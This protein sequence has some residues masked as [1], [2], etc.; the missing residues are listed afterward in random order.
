MDEKALVQT[1]FN[2]KKQKEDLESKQTD[3]KNQ[4]ATLDNEIETKEKDLLVFMKESD[5]KEIDLTDIVATYF[6]KENVS[7]TSDKDVLDYLKQNNYN[8]LITIKTT[9]SLNKNA[10]K[11]A[12]KTDENL[13]KALND[14]TVTNITEWVVVTT[15]E[16]HDKMLEHI[17]SNKKEK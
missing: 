9:E 10:L 17:E 7:Y 8:D 13:S 1:I 2:L 15:K 12:L 3:I 14:L 16:N 6:S 4:I 5:S 11:K